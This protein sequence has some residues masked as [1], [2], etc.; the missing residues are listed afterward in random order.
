MFRTP[1]LET[2]YVTWYLH[3][4]QFPDGVTVGNEEFIANRFIED[5]MDGRQS[6]SLVVMEV[7][8]PMS[9]EGTADV[10]VRFK[11]IT[12]HDMAR[13]LIELGYKVTDQDE[14]DGMTWAELLSIIP[15]D[16]E[17][18]EQHIRATD[19]NDCDA[20][21]YYVTGMRSDDQGLFL[22]LEPIQ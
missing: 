4:Q 7:I 14:P 12:T 8:L 13:Q 21:W 9:I 17:R 18:V 10:P 5:L 16:P 6:L 3:P 19:D 1:N 20:P 22:S 15:R 2:F 11:V